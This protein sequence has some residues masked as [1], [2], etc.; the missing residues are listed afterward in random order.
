MATTMRPTS[1]VDHRPIPLW[2]VN[3]SRKQGCSPATVRD[4]M[5]KLREAT[6]QFISD[7][8]ECGQME[9][10]GEWLAE[11]EA[12][13]VVVSVLDTRKAILSAASVADHDEDVKEEAYLES[14]DVADLKAL[15]AAKRK[16]IASESRALRFLESELDKATR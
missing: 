5:Q 16:A 3:M 4:R 6:R 10:V 15:I 12:A 11:F 9:L 8:A 2:H 13:A 7:M 1:T 14:R